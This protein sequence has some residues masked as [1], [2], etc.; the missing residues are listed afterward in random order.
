MFFL[1]ILE[2]IPCGY[3][4]LSPYSSNVS[5][6]WGVLYGIVTIILLQSRVT[7]MPPHVGSVILVL[8]ADIETIA[9]L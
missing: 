2:P 7:L 9:T 5:V 8:V 3:L 6:G 4:Q 1:K